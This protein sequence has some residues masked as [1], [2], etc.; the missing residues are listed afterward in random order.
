MVA[1]T[2]T[3]EVRTIQDTDEAPRTGSTTH[4]TTA[5]PT[6]RPAATA[7]MALDTATGPAA[8]KADTATIMASSPTNHQ[9]P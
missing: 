7:V 8:T 2:T 5:L 9:N 1:A 4:R 6:N 3:A